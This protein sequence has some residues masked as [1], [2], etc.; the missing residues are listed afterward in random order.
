MGLPLSPVL[1][2]IQGWNQ[3][4][5]GQGGPIQWQLWRKCSAWPQQHPQHPVSHLHTLK[6]AALVHRKRPQLQRQRA[7]VVNVLSVP[8]VS[9]LLWVLPIWLVSWVKKALSSRSLTNAAW[10]AGRKLATV[11]SV[12]RSLWTMSTWPRA[13]RSARPRS[14]KRF[15][16]VLMDALFAGHL[17]CIRGQTKTQSRGR[18]RNRPPLRWDCHLKVFLKYRKFYVAIHLPRR[19]RPQG[20]LFCYLKLLTIYI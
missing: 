19:V 16:D 15:P 8:L 11:H 12:T 9:R 10:V 14:A 13:K 3:N 5:Y 7:R 2:M 17:R 1:L 20:R 6:A 4:K 18:L